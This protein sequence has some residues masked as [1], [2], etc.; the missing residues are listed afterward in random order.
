[1]RRIQGFTLV[2]LMIVVAIVAILAA[3]AVPQYRDYV[4]RGKLQEGY[5]SLASLR[6]KMEQYYQ[7]NRRYSS[8]TGG[9]TCGIPGGNTPTVSEAKYFTFQCASGNPN[10]AGDQ[11]Y[12]ITA[13]GGTQVSGISFSIDYQ[14]TKRTTSVGSSEWT[15][16]ASNCWVLRK[17]GTC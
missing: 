11:T 10:A 7:D 5:T 12:T 13:V 8:T 17:D 4:L 16:P 9:G 15:L 6:T 2:E 1:M 3:F 14:N